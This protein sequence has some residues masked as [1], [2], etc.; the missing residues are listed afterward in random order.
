MKHK[1]IIIGTCIAVAAAVGAASVSVSAGTAIETA[2]AVTGQ[3][4]S[5]ASIGVRR[6]NLS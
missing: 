3:L 1:K 2:T 5:A 4:D 6:F